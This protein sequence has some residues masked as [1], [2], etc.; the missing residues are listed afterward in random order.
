MLKEHISNIVVFDKKSNTKKIKS[1]YV[2]L[3]AKKIVVSGAVQ[4]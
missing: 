2:M 3:L 1:A 4:V